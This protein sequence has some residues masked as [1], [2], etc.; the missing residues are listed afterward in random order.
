MKRPWYSKTLWANFILAALVLLIPGL[1]DKVGDQ[2][3][4]VAII[5]V[6]L[7]FR[8]FTKEQ[9]KLK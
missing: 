1:G 5:L 8:L 9:I 7:I 4:A 3:Q 2:G 6:N